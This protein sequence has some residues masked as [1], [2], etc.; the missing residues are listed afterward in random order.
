M[1]CIIALSLAAFAPLGFI[2]NDIFQAY[3]ARQAFRYAAKVEAANAAIDRA[4]TVHQA[5]TA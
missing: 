5:I 3:R 1:I 4:I 2:A